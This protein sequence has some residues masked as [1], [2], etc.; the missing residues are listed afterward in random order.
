[1]QDA[2][3]NILHF[4]RL[5]EWLTPTDFPKAASGRD[6]REPIYTVTP[7][8]TLP[9][10]DDHP[11]RRHRCD[12]A[13][14]RRARDGQGREWAYGVY[15]GPLDLN[16][17]R[18]EIESWLDDPVDNVVRD[19]RKP[20]DTAAIGFQVTGE[21]RVI[22]DSLVFSTFA[23]TYGRLRELNA[24]GVTSIPADTI[25]V[26]EFEK[27]EQEVAERFAAELSGAYLTVSGLNDF[28]ERLFNRLSLPKTKLSIYRCRVQCVV[29]PP[30]RPQERDAESNADEAL[31][32]LSSALEM[33][34]SHFRDDLALVQQA[35]KAGDAGKALLQYL[36]KTPG[37]QVDVRTDINEAW[38]LLNPA[39]FPRG[40]WPSE[41]RYPLVLSQQLSV[42]HAFQ[43]LGGNAAGLVA[44]NGPPGTGKTTL[45]K[46]VIAEIIVS[47]AQVLAHYEDPSRAFS[48]L[49]IAWESGSWTQRYAPVAPALSGFGI[50]VASSNN[51]AVE[52][53]TLELPK[54]DDVDPEWGGRV[55]PFTAIA[56]AML[57]DEQ[58][59]WSL[60]A[61]VLGKAKNRKAF[62]D[63]F[64]GWE[65]KTDDDHPKVP[66]ILKSAESP[67]ILP[68][69]E[70]VERFERAL[71]NEASIRLDRQDTYESAAKLRPS[72]EAYRAEHSKAQRLQHDL[73]ELEEKVAEA[74][75]QLELAEK[76]W[77]KARGHISATAKRNHEDAENT[78][79]DAI[80]RYELIAREL[81]ECRSR[82]ESSE[83]STPATLKQWIDKHIFEIKSVRGWREENRQLKKREAWLRDRLAGA[84][85]ARDKAATRLDE[86][87]N[88]LTGTAID[89]KC[90]A[91]HKMYFLQKSEVQHLNVE[92]AR[93]RES[94]NQA[95]EVAAQYKKVFDAADEELDIYAAYF[96]DGK[97]I[98][99]A[100]L[101]QDPADR[102]VISPWGDADWEEARVKVFL[103]ALDLH[104]A[105]V[106]AAGKPL[107]HNLRG[108]MKLLRG[109]APEDLPEGV[110]STLWASL[111][112]MVPVVSTTFASF[113]KQFQ[114][115][116]REE[117]GWLLI[118]E[119]GQA[120]PQYAAG[121][122]WRARSALV[123]GDP[124]QLTPVVTVP[125]RLQ[126]VL[127]EYSGVSMRWRPGATSAQALADAASSHGSWIGK[128]WVGSP[129]LVHRRCDSPMFEIANAVAYDNAMV[130][131]KPRKPSPLPE[132]RWFH[133][134]ARDA[135]GHW[136]P[137]EG[138]VVCNLV[139]SLAEA[140]V[141]F[142]DIFL[143]SPFRTVVAHLY[144]IASR[145]K[146]LQA[147][148]IHT[149]QGKEAK[150][151]ILVLGGNPEKQ[152]AKRWASSTP[153][154]VNVAVSRAKTRLY[155]I[156]DQDE[157]KQHPYF[158][159]CS[160][161]LALHQEEHESATERG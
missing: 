15:A 71:R 83:R 40:R 72:L 36:G 101:A 65:G 151:V 96:G 125:D 140:G 143:I 16:A 113:A 74:E 24:V 87:A 67:G 32:R 63:A 126:A 128:T 134:P 95:L 5:V 49:E 68:W 161:L 11:H 21:G 14:P 148:T 105:F 55:S 20:Q 61:A 34:N 41:G 115:L 117:L 69:G 120:A 111:F 59:A 144:A 80:E 92:L 123:V 38:R 57:P 133:V 19:E 18:E 104:D 81:R 45:L 78:M 58:E 141:S 82:V 35:V 46:D 154:L 89:A 8:E 131:G 3:A 135:Q 56:T 23:W 102:E 75:Q 10:E 97:I 127:A 54:A 27:V 114:H 42:N 103:A 9:W 139:E 62:A 150:V 12:E 39:R 122:M 25:T 121:A 44:V 50:V 22:A 1:M 116:G 64:W 28:L 37:R 153:N 2:P 77:R 53:V 142:E 51:G 76:Q 4:W 99:P 129:L 147:G 159:D 107:Q 93:C 48:T 108:M 136:I 84:R 130:H 30:S 88:Q 86:A 156:G 132:S 17:A 109:E 43:T 119:A 66:S 29:R 60:L 90:P 79:N 6:E 137:A 118:D 7:N 52:N 160:E 100:G 91:E 85:E 98:T 31:P 145:Y 106:F 157:W 47:R 13:S 33:L 138:R 112:L 158:D 146:G 155:V 124:L 73:Y 26:E 152:G 149:V 110:A 70:A 94:H